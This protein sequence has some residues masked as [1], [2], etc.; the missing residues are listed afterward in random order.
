MTKKLSIFQSISNIL[1]VNIL[2]L[3]SIFFF[4][5]SMCV[6][7]FYAQKLLYSN[8]GALVLGLR[9]GMLTKALPLLSYSRLIDDCL[10]KV[11]HRYTDGILIYF[12]N[13]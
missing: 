12:Y 5:L 11:A 7:T 10:T 6:Y 4:F 1:G 13:I 9:P 2:L 3:D 8:F